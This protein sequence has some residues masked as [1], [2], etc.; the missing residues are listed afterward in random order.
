MR[1]GEGG[2]K[3]SYS[4]P[5]GAHIGAS[6][7]MRASR[8]S[9]LEEWWGSTESA[10]RAR[11]IPLPCRTLLLDDRIHGTLMGPVGAP[12]IPTRTGHNAR[13]KVGFTTDRQDPDG[14]NHVQQGRT[15]TSPGLP[16]PPPPSPVRPTLF[17]RALPSSVPTIPP[18]FFLSSSPSLVRLLFIRP[19]PPPRSRRDP[20]HSPSPFRLSSHALLARAHAMPRQWQDR[21]LV[22][23]R[24]AFL[25]IARM[26]R[27]SVA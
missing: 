10:P 11:F 2:R 27:H 4:V 15:V 13:L 3:D 18:H 22:L 26:P 7:W 21:A 24:P 20:G 17:L 23:R 5:R 1:E 9:T 6:P 8:S 12:E 19:R 16:L 25:R 14:W